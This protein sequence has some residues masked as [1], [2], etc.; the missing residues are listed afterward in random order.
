V[1]HR[2]VVDREQF[3]KTAADWLAAAIERVV[4]SGGRCSI[5]LAG[6][7]TPRPVYW[8]LAQ[9]PF[10]RKVPWDRV[11]V[12]FGDE[13]AVP[14]DHPD[15]NY[16]AAREALLRHVAIPETQIFRMQAE[17][18]D[19]E[20]AATEYARMLP[21]RL[22]IV[23]LGMGPDGHT[24]SLFPASPGLEERVRK[25]VAVIGPKPPAA[26]L[27]I[28]PAVIAAAREVVVLV[29]GADKAATVAR[30]LTGPLAPRDLPAQ[31]ARDRTW[32]LDRAAAAGLA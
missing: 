27:T 19:R 29:T 30:A 13:R 12:Y 21:D 32:I 3:E 20:V 9:D 2:V 6:G 14:P 16:G 4:Q 11:W 31:L 8:T 22:D 24:A 25:V 17:R 10:K 5:A 28:T 26:R 18:A 23:I 1:T 7:S 15:S